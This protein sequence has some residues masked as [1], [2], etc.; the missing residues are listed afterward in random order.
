MIDACVSE[1]TIIFSDSGLGRGA[2]KLIL[3]L[4]EAITTDFSSVLYVRDVNIIVEPTRLSQSKHT[5][6]NIQS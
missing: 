4:I 3:H 1:V 6:I 2:N 5:H